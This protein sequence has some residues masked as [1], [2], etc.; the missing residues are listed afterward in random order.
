MEDLADEPII[1][2]RLDE[3]EEPTRRLLAAFGKGQTAGKQ[4]DV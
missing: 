1:I 2:L 4:A 3:T